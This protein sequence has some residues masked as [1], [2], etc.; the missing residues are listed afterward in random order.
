MF[1]I[2][3]I[4]SG[5]IGPDL[6]YGFASAL[7]GQPFKLWLHD[8]STDQLE[9]GM[10]RI[11]G[12]LNKAM[13]RGKLSPKR[14][15]TIQKSLVPTLRMQDLATC[16][17]VLEAASEDLAIKKQILQR[18]E[19]IVSPD[20]LIGFATSGL[21]RHW[22]CEGAKYPN[23]CMVNHPFYPAWRSLPMELVGSPDPALTRRMYDL[24]VTLGKV[25]IVTADT[26]CFAADDVF[27]NLEVEAF[28]ILQEGLASVEQIDSLVDQ[29]IGGGGPFRVADMTR[30]NLLIVHCQKL[31]AGFYRSA[32]FEPP[33][34]IDS[35]G[36]QPWS[37]FP[38]PNQD[39]DDSLKIQ[40]RERILAVV[41]GRTF[42]LIE[43]E[44]C[45]PSDL[46]WLLRNSLGFKKGVLALA[47]ELG[48]AEVARL[49][50]NYADQNPDFPV[51]ALIQKQHYPEFWENLVL[52]GPDA[53]GIVQLWV[54]RPEVLN[55]LNGQTIRELS[56][57]LTQL[58][59]DPQVKGI[60]FGGFAGALAGADIT[61][62]AALKS[63]EQGMELA[64][65][66]QALT[67]QMERLSKPIVA[68]CNGPVLGGGAELCMAAW[69]RV[70]GEKALIGQPEVNLGIIPGYGGSQRMPRLIGLQNGYRVLASA[71][72]FSA[73]EAVA[74]G[75]ASLVS[76]TPIEA[77]KQLIQQHLAG[78]I[79][80][81]PL[82]D[83]PLGLE[84]LQPVDIGHR[85]LATEAILRRA[86]QMGLTQPLA[87][88]L[89]QEAQAFAA[90]FQTQ[91]MAIGLANFMSNGPRVPAVFLNR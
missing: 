26:P 85:S 15:E 72:P 35:V 39:I 20:C 78:E 25:P 48:M 11:N 55:A 89:E 61:E 37:T 67:L 90:C 83:K 58:D 75:W 53:E 54:R 44:I 24:L 22:I 60:L 64:R 14:C 62:L 51:S 91:D 66:G 8:I 86:L 88:G 87:A 76:E 73:R 19:E 59:Q 31:L 49:V 36:N 80:L 41:L 32:W 21:P 52:E 27:C 56:D 71:Q 57:C 40:I 7:S 13:S 30:G 28:R 23:R 34:I 70:V 4:G 47:R 16:H 43:Q 50:Q 38:L 9:K 33:A 3:V 42:H 82:Q 6:A 5:S 18:L 79:T 77:G 69:A 74:W 84:P 2:A 10:A 12:Y 81:Q 17:Y 65:R 1:E 68:I 63:P 29:V 46:E 45:A